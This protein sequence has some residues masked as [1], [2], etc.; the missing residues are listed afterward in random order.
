[1]NQILQS[2]RT[3][4]IQLIETPAPMLK[5]GHLL[6]Q[7]TNSLISVGTEK[8]L[9]DFGRAGWIGKA[10]QQKDK[11][12]LVLDKARTDGLWPTLDAVRTKLDTPLPLGYSNV[13][14]VL[15]VG[16]GVTGFQVGDRVVSNGPH[17][18]V[19]CVP[20][21]L[22]AKI[23]K[24]VDDEAAS[25][26]ILGAIALQS[27]RLANPT[28][29]EKFVVIGLGLVGL[30]VCQILTANGC[31]VAGL[32]IDHA[33]CKYAHDL[34]VE[35]L[36]GDNTP[37]IMEQATTFSRGR[38]V[39]G[40]IIAAATKRSDP[41][42]QAARMTRKRGR[43]VLVGVTGMELNRADFFEKEITFQVSCSYGPGRYDDNYEIK[44]RD[45]PFGFVRWTE[46]RNFEGVLDLLARG[47]LRTESLI[48]H[49]FPF[50][51]AV[52]AYQ[53]LT[54][55]KDYFGILL[56]YD[57]KPNSSK[58]TTKIPAKSQPICVS[59]QPRLQPVIGLIGAGAFTRQVVIPVLHEYG[60]HLKYI[61]SSSGVSS[62]QLGKK[63]DFCTSD[64]RFIFEDGEVNTVLITTRHN[65][66][67]KL[68]MLA[69]EAGKHVFVEKPL[70]IKSQE[71]N[72]I[73]ALQNRLNETSTPPILM[74]G[75]NRRFAPHVL[76]IKELITRKNLPK[77]ML[78][79]V[80][81][82]TIPK[83]N[84]IHDPDIGGGRIIGEVCHFVDLLIFL[85]GG[86]P[87]SVKTAK[88]VPTN[89]PFGS[90]DNLSI[91]MEFPDGSLGIINYFAN[92]HKSF[93]KERLEIFCGNSILQLDNF[94]TL[95][96]LGW[97]GFKKNK[98]RRQDKGHKTEIF[99]F[100][101]AVRKG[102]SSPIPFNEISEV[103]KITIG[104]DGQFK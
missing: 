99:A 61:C 91:S 102:S 74:V 64:S 14:I 41:I 38:G 96:G 77:N 56:Q 71:L 36:Q 54:S 4:S 18:E 82:G 47:A 1:M 34:G 43:V 66:H 15:A 19:V 9:L 59:K 55:D 69:M 97:S 37:D 84:W 45:Y 23:P 93:P 7:S 87:R 5:D 44:G 12:R 10:N 17:A 35:V 26:T 50:A 104:A 57:K 42:N 72:D 24:E 11:V 30:L 103:T 27:V 6:I 40:V 63:F 90:Q 70:C 33:K 68:T 94:I 89:N 76:K 48:S 32:D 100:L 101:D 81:A 2:L 60:C 58:M 86:T 73:V 53:L 52:D 28:I 13:G 98:L 8:M 75:F 88:M 29:G 78:M 92:G 67:A 79:T 46:Q 21:N 16:H 83:E 95:R 25:L 51:E 49:R 20:S 65:S 62:S 31:Q 85:A 39:D 22:C 80:N 3:G